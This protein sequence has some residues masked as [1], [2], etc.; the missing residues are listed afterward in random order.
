MRSP[1]ETDAIIARRARAGDPP[2]RI[3]DAI[4]LPVQDVRD[5]MF[6]LGFDG[7]PGSHNSKYHVHPMWDADPEE[8][9]MAI[10]QRQHDGAARAL[11]GRA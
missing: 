8:R 9:R 3:A 2:Y 6:A 7:G 1:E 10:W 4:G 5:R 11:R